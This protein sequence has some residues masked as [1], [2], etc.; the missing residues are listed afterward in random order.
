Y[1]P[2]K[3]IFVFCFLFTLRSCRFFTLLCGFDFTVMRRLFIPFPS[4]FLRLFIPFP[5]CCRCLQQRLFIPFPCCCCF[6]LF[7]N[8]PSISPA[9]SLIFCFA[10]FCHSSFDFALAASLMISIPVFAACFATSFTPVLI[11]SGVLLISPRIPPRSF[12]KIEP[13]PAPLCPYISPRN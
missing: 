4:C 13:T 1:I 7:P 3:S 10:D 6:I 2:R 5:C 9:L 11:H 8:V 12:A